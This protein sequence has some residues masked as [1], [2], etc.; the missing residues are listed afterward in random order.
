MVIGP[1]LA[2]CSRNRVN[3]G[4]SSA[5]HGLADKSVDWHGLKAQQQITRR[6]AN[7]DGEAGEEQPEHQPTA[8]KRKRKLQQHA[9]ESQQQDQQLMKPGGAIKALLTTKRVRPLYWPVI[10]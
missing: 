4:D 10:A 6:E 5:I 9:D 2:I 3:T 7:R 8:A 1:R